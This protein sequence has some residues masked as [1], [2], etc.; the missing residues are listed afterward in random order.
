MEK[1][2][3]ARKLYK[4]MRLWELPDQYVAEPID[5][6]SGSCLVVKRDGSMTLVGLCF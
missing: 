6:S 5:G 3:H 1:T 4:R 2:D